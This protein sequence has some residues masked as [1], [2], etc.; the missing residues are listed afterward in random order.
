MHIFGHGFSFIGWGI[1]FFCYVDDYGK[2]GER[3]EASD[4]RI[5]EMSL[6][7]DVCFGA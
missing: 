5:G 4:W 3:A 7:L 2:A 1:I 6:S